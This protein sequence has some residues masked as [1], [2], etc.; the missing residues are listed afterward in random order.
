MRHVRVFGAGGVGRNS[1]TPKSWQYDSHTWRG[2]VAAGRTQMSEVVETASTAGVGVPL[3]TYPPR[4]RNARG[5]STTDSGSFAIP[6]QVLALQLL[7][8]A[9]V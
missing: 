5:L 8:H 2:Y 1:A 9:Y 3:S 4:T 7:S 6:T